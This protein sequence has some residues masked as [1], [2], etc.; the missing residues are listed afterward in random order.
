[1]RIPNRAEVTTQFSELEAFAHAAE[2][3]SD[4]IT[5]NTPPQ[6]AEIVDESERL[7]FRPSMELQIAGLSLLGDTD[8]SE[9]QHHVVAFACYAVDLQLWGW[10]AA[11][12]CHPRI[13]FSLS[14]SAL[15]ACIFGIAATLDYDT[16]RGIWE[17]HKGTGSYVLKRTKNISADTRWLLE[18]AWKLL[19][20]MGHASSGPVLSALTR[21]CDG[22]QTR[23]GITFAGQ[24]AGPLDARQLEG[25]AH[26]FSATATAAARFF[27][28]GIAPMLSASEEWTR[29]LSA[30]EDQLDAPVATP[31]YLAPHVERYRKE[32][33]ARPQRGEDT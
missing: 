8:L 19:A 28:I 13:A 29:R 14:R 11:V 5:K 4:W 31:D 26:A 32:M 25:C 20:A 16:F 12:N 30:I 33:G 7:V 10:F 24:F 3:Y 2:I 17:S 18:N 6:S 21:F 9:P 23:H 22:E 27:A 1:M 15:E